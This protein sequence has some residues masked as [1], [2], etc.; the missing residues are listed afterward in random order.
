MPNP[1]RYV[2]H[3]YRR[4]GSGRTM[5]VAGLLERIGNGTR[6][7]FSSGAELWSLL[8]EVP[9]ASSGTGGQTGKR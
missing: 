9:E 4:E 1:E 7:P 2:I 6:Q 8:N 5:R 3:I